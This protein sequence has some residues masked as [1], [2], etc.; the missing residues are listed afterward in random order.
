MAKYKD[1]YNEAVSKAKE[2]FNF[3]YN[4]EIIEIKT[5]ELNKSFVI[6]IYGEKTLVTYIYHNKEIWNYENQSN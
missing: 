6:T 5:E 3:D 2:E 4:E 1:A